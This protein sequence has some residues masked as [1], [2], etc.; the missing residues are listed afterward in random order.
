[1]ICTEGVPQFREGWQATPRGVNYKPLTT[2]ASLPAQAASLQRALGS[3]LRDL[4]WGVRTTGGAITSMWLALWC[5]QGERA[6]HFTQE[7]SAPRG[8]AK[9]PFLFCA[10]PWTEVLIFHSTGAQLPDNH[11][12]HTCSVLSPSS[13]H[14]SYL[15]ISFCLPW[16][17]ILVSIYYTFCPRH[18]SLSSQNAY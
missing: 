12:P 9:G 11:L 10:R 18:I 4:H 13:K 15:T 16:G 14:V 3:A 5:S 17:V 7:K 1:M 8:E 2:L 6:F